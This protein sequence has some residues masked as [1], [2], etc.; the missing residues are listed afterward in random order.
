MARNNRDPTIQALVALWAYGL[1][2]SHGV[3]RADDYAVRVIEEAVQ[4]AEASSDATVG[5]VTFGLGQTLLSRDAEADR[6]RGLELMMRI[7]D[8]LLSG[9]IAFLVPVADVWIAREKARQGDHDGAI[10]VMRKAVDE[11][12]QSGRP[13]YGV[14]G[15]GVLVE[16]LLERGLEGDLDEA[17]EAFARL[18]NISTEDG[19]AV[20]EIMRLRLRALLAR[21][22]GD[23]VAFQESA[24]RYRDM[25]KLLGFEGH[26]DWAEAMIKGGE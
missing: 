11:L 4:T 19:S 6:A 2:I 14:W 15:T 13:F 7:R 9:S 22:R 21:A 20:L 26:I 1:P 18:A 10:P 12:H 3:L 23:D 16:T 8:M 24:N 5:V 25:A 17:Q